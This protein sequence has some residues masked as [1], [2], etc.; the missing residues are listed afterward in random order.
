MTTFAIAFKY[1]TFNSHNTLSRYA[2]YGLCALLIA[3]FAVR[4]IGCN[5]PQPA[6][7]P[8]HGTTVTPTVSIPTPEFS[9][10]NAFSYIEKQISFGPRVPNTKQHAAC[11]AWL[12]DT[13]SKMA[14]EVMVQEGK[15]KAYNGTM[16]DMKNIIAS[17]NPGAKERVLLCAHWDT[18]HVADKDP[19]ISKQNKPIDGADDGGSGV[20][21][22]LEIARILK[23][24][25]LKNGIGVDI[26]LF[27]TEDY[28]E[29]EGRESPMTQTE[30]LSYWCLGS[31]F[32]ART[33]HKPNYKA[34]WGILLDMVGS[35]GAFFP[36][37][38]ASLKFNG[39]LVDRVWSEASNLGYS[40]F[41]SSDIQTEIIDDHINVNLLRGIP[42]IDIINMPAQGN[43]LFGA[44]HHTSADN[45]SIISKA[46][47]KAVGQTVTNI[48]YKEPNAVQ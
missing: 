34:R 16:L 32:W 6:P 13:L 25:P 31:E 1:H 26:I 17:F 8:N 7:D 4:F 11:A 9:A 19:D 43:R 14:D 10:D 40:G 20:G 48:V 42:T 35:N 45:I 30:R 5:N 44:Y 24:N 29:P 12:K 2:I 41:F 47:L 28:G 15:V 18:R 33:P 37:E 38:G 39:Y 22:L 36:K 27:D 23:N 46:T 21:V 3:A